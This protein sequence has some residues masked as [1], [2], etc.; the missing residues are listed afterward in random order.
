VAQSCGFYDS[1]HFARAFRAAAGVTASQYR[2]LA[3]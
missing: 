2:A 1:A 3:T